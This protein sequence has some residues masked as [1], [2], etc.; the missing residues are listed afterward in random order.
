MNYDGFVV[1]GLLLVITSVCDASTGEIQRLLVRHDGSALRNAWLEFAI[2]ISPVDIEQWK[3]S[4]CLSH[5]YAV[6][7]ASCVSCYDTRSVTSQQLCFSSALER[8]SPVYRINPICFLT[9]NQKSF[10]NPALFIFLHAHL[11]SISRTK[12]QAT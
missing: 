1:C 3:E 7:K 2:A 4:S 10:L 5:L 9:R 6:F 12:I 8:A 11:G